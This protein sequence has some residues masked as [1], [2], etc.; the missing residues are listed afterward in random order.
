MSADLAKCKFV[1]PELH[2]LGHIVG[3]QGC[4]VAI[5]Q[6]WPAPKDNN[7]LQKFWGLANYS[8]TFEWNADCAFDGIKHALLQCSCAGPARFE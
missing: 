8:D 5:L 1:Q 6:D 3:A 2:F 7:S 4:K